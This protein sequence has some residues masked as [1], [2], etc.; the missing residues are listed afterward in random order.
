MGLTGK[1]LGKLGRG[2][3]F[4]AEKG[5]EGRANRFGMGSI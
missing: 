5:V 2:S 1:N 3:A 4:T